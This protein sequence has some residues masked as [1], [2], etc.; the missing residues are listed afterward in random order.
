MREAIGTGLSEAPSLPILRP[1]SLRAV[2][3]DGKTNVFTSYRGSRVDGRDKR[4]LLPEICCNGNYVRRGLRSRCVKQSGLGSRR[5]P[6]SQE[7]D[8]SAKQSNIILLLLLLKHRRSRKGPPDCFIRQKPLIPA[9]RELFVVSTFLVSD[10]IP[11]NLTRLLSPIGAS[12]LHRRSAVNSAPCCLVANAL[13]FD[14]SRV[15][16]SVRVAAGLSAGYLH[17]KPIFSA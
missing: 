8:T 6:H 13:Y 10:T 15:R 16:R 12:R 9:E 4:S 17:W 2:A 7:F 11:G 3:Q 1:W 5:P 14:A